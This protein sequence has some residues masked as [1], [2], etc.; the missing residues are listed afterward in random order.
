MEKSRLSYKGLAKQ[1][2]RL[3]ANDS[4]L[5]TSSSDIDENYVNNE[6][7]FRNQTNQNQDDLPKNRSISNL[8]KAVKKGEKSIKKSIDVVQLNTKKQRSKSRSKS[9]NKTVTIDGKSCHKEK[10]D[11]KVAI[12]KMHKTIGSQQKKLKGLY[13]KI[14]QE[15]DETKNLTVEAFEGRKKD[16]ILKDLQEKLGQSQ[17]NELHLIK[18]L[19]EQQQ[20]GKEAL[21]KLYELQDES[22]AEIEKVKKYYKDYYYRINLEDKEDLESQIRM[23]E[24]EIRVIKSEKEEQQENIK[25][26]QEGKYD[27]ILAE[28]KRVDNDLSRRT[29]EFE[30]LTQE[31]DN[32]LGENEN[33]KAENERLIKVNQAY[34]DEKMFSTTKDNE[35]LMRENDA[36]RDQVTNL[37]QQLLENDDMSEKEIS[38]LSDSLCSLQNELRELKSSM[39]SRND[40]TTQDIQERMKLKRQI[41]ELT[42][43]NEDKVRMLKEKDINYREQLELINEK[44][45]NLQNEL[46]KVSGYEM[47]IEELNKEL[48]TKNIGLQ[49]AKKNYKEKLH[50]RKKIQLEQK[51]E[52]SNIYNELVGEVKTLKFEIDTAGL[53][54]RKILNRNNY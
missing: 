22:I 32:V 48:M 9:F 15:R 5:T 10:Q 44:V 2:E 39:R 46:K 49:Q 40:D 13:Q 50:S 35:K 31:H 19:N 14:I 38:K 27:Q 26:K 53:G 18:E 51:R 30:R 42:S 33:Y 6:K 8:K 45:S 36:L 24:S 11:M 52:W 34:F 1:A 7:S 3:L 41:D 29:H 43:E 20:I 28:M 21:Q 47:K 16:P 37:H 4:I 23:L 12:D 25:S 17:A 54:S